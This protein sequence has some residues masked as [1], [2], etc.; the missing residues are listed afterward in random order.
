MVDLNKVSFGYP[1]AN[2]RFWSMFPLTRVPFW[3][4]LFLTPTLASTNFLHGP[5]WVDCRASLL[6]PLKFEQSMTNFHLLFDSLVGFNR[7]CHYWTC[8]FFP[9]DLSK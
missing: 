2:H 8:F 7:T 3:V 5:F 6:L 4:D 9:G 1:P